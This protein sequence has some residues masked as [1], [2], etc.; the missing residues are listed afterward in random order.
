M[1]NEFKWWQISYTISGRTKETDIEFDRTILSGNIDTCNIGKGIMGAFLKNVFRDVMI[2]HSNYHFQ[3]PVKKGK[4]YA[5]NVPAIDDTLLPT[6]ILGLH[7]AG[8][9]LFT[10]TF[11]GKIE[12]VK[13]IIH[14]TT[15]K[16]VFTIKANK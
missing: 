1:K 13:G 8:E 6:H 7:T 11:K 12:N 3:C 5:N 9:Y 2:K 14:L 10:L 16:C 4:L 15:V